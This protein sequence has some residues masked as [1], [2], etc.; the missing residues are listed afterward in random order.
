MGCHA[1]IIYVCHVGDITISGVTLTVD[2]DLNGASPQFTLTCS[3]TGGPATTVTWTRDSV[4]VT[5]GNE[6]VLDNQVTATYTHT[7]TATS[8]GEYTCTVN[9]DKPSTASA[10]ITVEG[11]V[12]VIILLTLGVHAQRGLWYLVSVSV[13]LR[14][15][16]HSSVDIAHFYA[17]NKVHTALYM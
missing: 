12:H 4:T 15:C 13:C 7:L 11:I 5:E 3:S 9:N 17:Q 14:V 16:Y 10:N 1:H 6:T 8:A 2:S